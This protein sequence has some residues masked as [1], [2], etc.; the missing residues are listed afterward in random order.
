MLKVDGPD[1]DG[2]MVGGFA[3]WGS[4]GGFARAFEQVC[5]VVCVVCVVCV[6]LC[7]VFVLCVMCDV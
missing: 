1:T 3:R 5:C 7:V 6:S 2:A 4:R